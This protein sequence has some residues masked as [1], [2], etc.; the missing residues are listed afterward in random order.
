MLTTLLRR[1]FMWMEYL[2]DMSNLRDQ[3]EKARIQ[4]LN[5]KLFPRDRVSLDTS[6]SGPKSVLHAGYRYRFR[7]IHNIDASWLYRTNIS[8]S[9]S[10]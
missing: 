4:L 3:G 8:K 1:G 5:C 10:K 2:P 6:Y 9:A 7:V